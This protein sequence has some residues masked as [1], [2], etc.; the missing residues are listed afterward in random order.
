MV[1]TNKTID[2][3]SHISKVLKNFS[4]SSLWSI[5]LFSASAV[6]TVLIARSKPVEPQLATTTTTPRSEVSSQLSSLQPKVP[7]PPSIL[8]SVE[9]TDT[10]SDISSKSKDS[11]AK[12]S[13]NPKSSAIVPKSSSKSQD[14]PTTDKST[15][16]KKAAPKTS[17]TQAKSS[18]TPQKSTAK[19]PSPPPITPEMEISVALKMDADSIQIGS[20]TSATISDSNGKVIKTI[21]ANQGFQVRANGSALSFGGSQL[22]YAVWIQPT[23]GGYFSLENNWYRGR[24]LVVS[25]GNSLLAI[26]YVDLEHYLYSVVGSEM[27]PTASIEALK[28]QAIAA[29]SYALVHLIRPA[30]SWYNLG[31]TT[32]WQAYNGVEKEYNTTQKAVRDTAGMILSYKGGVVESLYAAT[33]EIVARAHKGRGM[34][35]TGAYKLAESGYDYQQILGYYYPGVQLARLELEQE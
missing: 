32:R 35:Q 13:S 3:M 12:S 24:L 11:Q 20:S 8:T 7:P 15:A 29:R 28:A 30:S 2:R 17:T 19:K 5:G 21:S 22:P 9:P 16:T 25:Q 33:D 27:H 31:A 4:Y 10:K 23:K 6:L 26:N 34:S 14:K 18:K 1:K